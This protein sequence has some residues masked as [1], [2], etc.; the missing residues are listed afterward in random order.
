MLELVEVLM[1][2]IVIIDLVVNSLDEKYFDKQIKYLEKNQLDL[3]QVNDYHQHHQQ[4]L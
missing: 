4:D 2:L 1:L 3:F